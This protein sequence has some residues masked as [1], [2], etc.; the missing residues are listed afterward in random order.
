MA[1]L[2][3]DHTVTARSCRS[4]SLNEL[5]SAKFGTC[6]DG[7]RTRTYV[8]RDGNTCSEALTTLPTETVSCD[9]TIEDYEP[10]YGPCS[11]GTRPL[12]QWTRKTDCTSGFEPPTNAQIGQGASV[13]CD[14]RAEDLRS[15]YSDCVNNK[16][17][18]IWYFEHTCISD[19]VLPEPVFI[20]CDIRCNAGQFLKAPHT[21]CQDCPPGTHSSTYRSALDEVPSPELPDNMFT[22]CNSLSEKAC[23]S[24]WQRD[25]TTFTAKPGHDAHN[26]DTYLTYKVHVLHYPASVRFYY[27]VS[28][29]KNFDELQVFV[30]GKK[31]IS[32]SGESLSDFLQTSI[33]LDES[34][35]NGLHIV[36]FVYHKDRGVSEGNDTAQIRD[37][38]VNSTMAYAHECLPC[39]PGTYNNRTKAEYCTQ[40]PRNT[41]SAGNAVTCTDCKPKEWAPPGSAA[42][43]LR[44]P[45]TADDYSPKHGKCKST[46]K[47]TESFFLNNDL[48]SG[49]VT[50]PPDREVDCVPCPAGTF[51][52]GNLCRFC[53]PGTASSAEKDT[54]EDCPTGT[55]AVRGFNYTDFSSFEDVWP[56]KW[57][58]STWAPQEHE[59]KV[60]SKSKVVLSSGHQVARGEFPSSLEIAL[61]MYMPG[62]LRLEFEWGQ[63]IGSQ[64]LMVTSKST[65]ELLTF[66]ATYL[67][68]GS[69]PYVLESPLIPKGPN[70]LE[71]SYR[72]PGLGHFVA[73]SA[74]SLEGVDEAGAGECMSCPKGHECHDRHQDTPCS[75]GT[76]NDKEMSTCKPC[77]GNTASRHHGSETCNECHRGTFPDTE[78]RMCVTNCQYEALVNGLQYE[79]DFSALKNTVFGPVTSKGGPWKSSIEQLDWPLIRENDRDSSSKLYFANLCGSVDDE[80]RTL[81]HDYYEL[82]PPSYVCQRFGESY[83]NVVATS[84]ED[85]SLRNASDPTGGFQF[86][87]G[88]RECSFSNVANTVSVKILVDCDPNVLPNQQQLQLMFDGPSTPTKD[89]DNA[90]HCELHFKLASPFACPLCNDTDIDFQESFCS[91]QGKKTRTAVRKP[92]AMCNLGKTS[93]TLLACQPCTDADVKPVYSDCV[94]DERTK[95]FMQTNDKCTMTEEQL[96]TQREACKACTLDDYESHVTL[97]KE[98]QQV[99]VYVL[100][101]NSTC[102]ENGGKL[103]PPQVQECSTVE[104]VMGT[105]VGGMP[106]ELWVII[107]IVLFLGLALLLILACRSVRRWKHQYYALHQGSGA[108]TSAVQLE[109]Q[110]DQS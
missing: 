44:P 82:L 71:I 5:Y 106:L 102:D 72:G 19:G 48:C 101:K 84:I 50:T 105:R 27:W 100:P 93:Q 104:E 56:E 76:Y 53:P 11:N 96:T 21:E 94:Q 17:N 10:T 23:T 77:E 4:Y 8:P 86:H 57:A 22:G 98:G 107:I 81:C 45:C 7:T 59:S 12:T 67:T 46:E 85:V 36:K 13:L 20:P 78:H 68:E 30:D 89:P 61:E 29:E 31:M 37:L 70:T 80:N 43:Q 39:P 25:G 6:G 51:R 49:G 73:V 1:A 95:Q 18:V 3:A 65:Q 26:T 88:G 74:L 79:Y 69:P 58:T 32:R 24:V 16:R 109:F 90:T 14:C 55:V 42:C 41:F 91:P 99:R 60:M 15:L 35:R 103:L 28:S 108:T 52:D 47:R 40:C 97:C 34:S 9:C 66:T 87:Y 110:G 64:S 33:P 38:Q 63:S 83:A 54:C 92:G 75:P 62:K 2:V